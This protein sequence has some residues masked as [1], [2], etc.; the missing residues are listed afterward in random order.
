MGTSIEI[1]Y[2]GYLI[3]EHLVRLTG[4]GPETF[5]VIATAHQTILDEIV[6]IKSNYV[7]LEIGCAIG[8][9]AIPLTDKLTHGRYYGVDI[10]YPSIE[11]CSNNITPLHP[12]FTFHHFD[13][14]DQLHNPSGV[15]KTTDIHLPLE[16][17]SVDRIIVWS[18][19]THMYMEDIL[20]YFKEFKRCLKP[21]GLTY[22]TCFIFDDMSIAST[23]KIYPAEFNLRFEHELS[24][25]TLY[26]VRT[27]TKSP[28]DAF[29]RN[30]L[31]E[32]SG[33]KLAR[34]IKGDWSKFYGGGQDALVL[35][36]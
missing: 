8:R 2:K 4:G 7:V 6:G 24:V 19:F 28:Y 23:K 29:L 25:S 30:L 10:I 1:K 12:N 14:K 33:L 32:T 21:G 18:V 20:H 27:T 36:I 3:P 9:D 13:V 17:C 5:D 15:M 16:D 22:A 34:F 26:D 11:W 35:T 31:I